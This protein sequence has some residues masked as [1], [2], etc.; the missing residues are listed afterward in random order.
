[1]TSRRLLFHLARADF[2]ERARRYSFLITL[3]LMI[4]VAYLFIP[5]V[6]A[7]YVTIDID[8][9]RG[10]YNSA[11]IGAAVAMLAGAY[12]GLVS[13]YVVKGAVSRDRETGVGQIIATTPI[14][15]TFYLFGKWLS[16]FAVL[17]AMLVILIVASGVMQLVRGEVTQ[18]DIWPL[19]VPFLL[20]ALPTWAVVA[21]LAVLF[22]TVRWLR[23]G[24]ATWPTSFCTYF[25]SSLL[26]SRP[27]VS[28]ELWSRGRPQQSRGIAADRRVA[29]SLKPMRYRCWVAK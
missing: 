14:S 8:G 13:F 19:V 26:S 27:R 5:T 15:K 6:D 22:D 25:P 21:A 7:S 18:I 29:W 17:T 20:I 28:S 9:Y 10:V 12:L 3:G 24:S 16:N 1:M 4:V 11:W 2:L 23:G